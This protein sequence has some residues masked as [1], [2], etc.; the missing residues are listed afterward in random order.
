M[1][2]SEIRQIMVELGKLDIKIDGINKALDEIK[3]GKLGICQIHS[4]D[5]N[6]IKASVFRL[7][8]GDGRANTEASHEREG[9]KLEV[10]RGLFTLTNISSSKV[11]SVAKVGRDLVFGATLLWLALKLWGGSTVTPT[12]HHRQGQVSAGQ[13]I[14]DET[15][16]M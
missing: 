14:M 6:A 11:V 12:E 15:K 1:S 13:A 8:H 10:L 5:I 4:A 3:G 16:Q 7:E 2:D 9:A